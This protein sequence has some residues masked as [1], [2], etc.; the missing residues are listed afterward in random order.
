MWIVSFLIDFIPSTFLYICLLRWHIKLCYIT[1]KQ[2]SRRALS[3]VPTESRSERMFSFSLSRT[4]SSTIPLL[5][6]NP[7]SSEYLCKVSRCSF[8]TSIERVP[9]ALAC[10]FI[11]QKFNSPSP[12]LRASSPQGAR[13]KLVFLIIFF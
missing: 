8:E 1:S 7:L 4:C 12:T 13:G 9:D 5:S 6:I 11:F 2:R 3:D 10:I